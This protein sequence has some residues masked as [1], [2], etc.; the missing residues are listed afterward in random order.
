MSKGM[1]YIA[2]VLIG[3]G[4]GELYGLFILGP[5]MESL[6]AS[7]AIGLAIGIGLGNGLGIYM[8]ESN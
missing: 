3:M 7:L 5:M 4:I 8:K 2:G 6:E 1:R